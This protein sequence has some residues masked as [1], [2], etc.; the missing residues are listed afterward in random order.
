MQPGVKVGEIGRKIED[1]I[2]GWGYQPIKNLMGHK[3]ERFV[4]HSGK[5]IPNVSTFN[6]SR[7]CTGEVYAVEPFLT[8]ST[9]AGSVVE[10]DKGAIYRLHKEKRLKSKQ[11]KKLISIIRA[12][13][14]TLP[15]SFRWLKQ[16]MEDSALTRAFQEL[17]ESGCL[18]VYPILVEKRGAPVAQAEHTIL[19][20]DNGCNILTL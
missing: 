9:G 7:I 16:E 19:I 3:L 13:F 4:L 2:K 12:N 20:T 8:T 5:S 6:G 18:M 1:V 14:Y 17:L 11:A 10:A 15:F